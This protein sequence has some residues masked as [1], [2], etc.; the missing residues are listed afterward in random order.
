MG[1]KESVLIVHDVLRRFVSSIFVNAGATQRQAELI[2]AQLVEANLTGHDSHGVGS[3]PV[4]INNVISGDLPLDQTLS[5]ELDT[6]PVLVCDGNGGPGQVMGHDAMAL[7]IAKAREHGVCLLG[8]RNSHHLGRIGHWAETCAATGLASI[9]FVNVISTPSVAPFGGVRARIGTNPFSVGMPR[10]GRHPI[11]VDFA[12]SKYAKGKIR[13]SLNSGHP[14]PD[15]V[16]LTPD[17]EPTNDPAVLFGK[18]GG[19]LL[20]F[21]EHKGWGLGLACELL[22]AALTGGRTQSGPKKSNAVI[23]SMLS[24]LISPDRLGTS[25]SYYSEVERFIAWAQSEENEAVLLPGDPE[26]LNRERRLTEGIPIDLR[27][28]KDITDAAAKVGVVPPHATDVDNVRK[29]TL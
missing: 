19:I 18:P 7:G 23:N 4:Y 9:H 11:I 27:S 20:P 29:V 13:V 15:G 22:G 26:S 17:G 10:A 3:I 16:L 6:G 8:L 24:I 12:T 28:W 14:L 1:D 2:S 25:A 5:V 21:G